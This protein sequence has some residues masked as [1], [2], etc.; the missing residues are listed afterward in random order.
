MPVGVY[1]VTLYTHQRHNKQMAC[2]KAHGFALT[3]MPEKGGLRFN[4]PIGFS[5]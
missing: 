5:F 3:L 1:A 2:F 4:Y